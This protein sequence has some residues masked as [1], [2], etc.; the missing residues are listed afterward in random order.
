M[1]SLLASADIIV[2]SLKTEIP[3]AVPSKLY[4]AMAS[5]C[6]VVLVASGEGADVVRDHGA[7][8]VVEPGDV[9]G[10]VAAIRDLRA[11]R[12]AARECAAS[13][14]AAVQR[15]FDR[16]TICSAFIDY[17]EAELPGPGVA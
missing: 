4:E 12:V 8:I 1:P 6:P 16:A 11:N 9:E 17:L 3:G 15:H 7:G 2:V 10:V 13:G 14:R 5:G